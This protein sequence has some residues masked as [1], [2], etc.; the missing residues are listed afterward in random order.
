MKES[1]M[2]EDTLRG[3]DITGS[4]HPCCLRP[5]GLLTHDSVTKCTLVTLAHGSSD[6]RGWMVKS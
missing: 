5:L 3:G 1:E 2:A 4:G 6:Q